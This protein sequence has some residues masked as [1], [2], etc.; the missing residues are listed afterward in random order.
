MARA[1]YVVERVD[2]TLMVRSV[3]LSLDPLAVLLDRLPPELGPLDGE[4]VPLEGGS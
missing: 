2:A 4:P 3:H 1:A